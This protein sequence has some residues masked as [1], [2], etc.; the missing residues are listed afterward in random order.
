M[1]P[2]LRPSPKNL[3]RMWGKSFY[4]SAEFFLLIFLNSPTRRVTEIPHA[5]IIWRLSGS[6]DYFLDSHE[7]LKCSGSVTHADTGVPSRFPGENV[8]LMIVSATAWLSSAFE[9]EIISA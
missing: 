9:L 4:W 2:D 1:R 3:S 6:Y 5:T 8:D 7:L